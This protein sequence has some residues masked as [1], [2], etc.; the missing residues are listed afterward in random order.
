VSEGVGSPGFLSKIKGSPFL[1]ILPAL[2]A[3]ILIILYP[4]AYDIFISFTNMN[5]FHFRDFT[6]VS[7]IWTNYS[8]VFTDPAFVQIMENT[9][10]WTFANVL[11]TV[12]IGLVLAFLLNTKTRGKTVYRMFMI[13]PWAMPSF[14]TLLI[15]KGM[16]NY[17]F[18]IVNALLGQLGIRSINWL[19]GSCATAFAAIVIANI[20]LGY[21]FMMVIFSGALQSIP[22]ELYEAAS[23]DGAVGFNQ[24]RYIMV[25]LIK[26]TIMLALLLGSIWTF[27]NFNSAFLITGGGP[28][29]CTT[30]FITQ[31][32]NQAFTSTFPN[33]AVAATYAFIAFVILLIPGLFWTRFT[34]LTRRAA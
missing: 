3:L 10:I 28:G 19:N 13:V 25:P 17:Q 16:Y 21:P 2:A 14:I 12:G 26:P 4:F 31:A 29:I 11:P 32:Y 30:I 8:F 9:F 1:F 27:N 7:P 18:G 6:L 24:F 23:I 5:V 33:Y 20:W 15:W 34:G 22:N